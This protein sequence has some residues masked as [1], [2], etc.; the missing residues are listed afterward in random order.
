M[1][2]KVVTKELCSEFNELRAK[3]EIYGS[4]EIYKVLKPFGFGDGRAIS[5]LLKLNIVQRISR[6]SYKLSSEPVHISKLNNALD[7]IRKSRKTVSKK[8]IESNSEEIAIELLKSLGYRVSKPVIDLDAAIK[9]PSLAVSCFLK[10]VN[11]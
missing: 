11:L 1:N 3:Q 9:N 5:V 7:L 2:K 10:W 6:G 8:P 4:V